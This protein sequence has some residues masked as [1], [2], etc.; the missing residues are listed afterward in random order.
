MGTSRQCLEPAPWQAFRPCE[1]D[2]LVY[3]IFLM[4]LHWKNG[5]WDLSASHDLVYMYLNRDLRTVLAG[6]FRLWMRIWTF[7]VVECQAK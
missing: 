6:N 4:V 7:L 3:R 2:N 5:L 1:A